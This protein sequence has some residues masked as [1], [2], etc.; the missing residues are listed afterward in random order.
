MALGLKVP[1]LTGVELF[2]AILGISAEMAIWGGIRWAPAY[3]RLAR[4]YSGLGRKNFKLRYYPSDYVAEFNGWSIPILM[5]GAFPWRE[6]ALRP[7]RVQRADRRS[8]SGEASG[9]QR[10]TSGAIAMAVATASGPR[11][12]ERVPS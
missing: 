6:N 9:S 3:A 2:S 1:T 8:R 10:S 11:V 7:Q 5:D 4:N 12:V